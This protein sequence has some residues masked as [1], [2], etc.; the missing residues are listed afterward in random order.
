[1]EGTRFHGKQKLRHLLPINVNGE[2]VK[3]GRIS[4][5]GEAPKQVCFEVGR[6][7]FE[8]WFSRLKLTE[9]QEVAKNVPGHN[10]PAGNQC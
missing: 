6:N 5:E 2:L 9:I 10:E 8:V 7:L 4:Q 3:H 1:M